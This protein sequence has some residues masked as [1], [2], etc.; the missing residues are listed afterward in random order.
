MSTEPSPASTN[1]DLA[2]AEEAT[3]VTVTESVIREAVVAALV[4]A[5]GG[6]G[7]DCPHPPPGEGPCEDCD[8]DQVMRAVW[9]LI[10]SREVHHRPLTGQAP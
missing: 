1:L 7:P 6:A 5:H 4:A 2:I 8:A 10:L 3:V 9:P